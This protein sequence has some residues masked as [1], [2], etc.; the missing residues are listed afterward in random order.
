MPLLHTIN[1]S[2]YY[3]Y[4]DQDFHT[5]SYSPILQSNNE[6]PYPFFLAISDSVNRSSHR[7]T[8]VPIF[9]D[10]I[11][12]QV[13]SEGDRTLQHYSSKS[14]KVPSISPPSLRPEAKPIHPTYPPPVQL[15][16]Q[17]KP[18]IPSRAHSDD[19]SPKLVTDEVVKTFFHRPLPFTLTTSSGSSGSGTSS[20]GS[21]SFRPRVPT[22]VWYRMFS[23]P[24]QADIKDRDENWRRKIG[25]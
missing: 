7:S 10:Q 19:G 22:L 11:R 14:T 9:L 4:S 8:S 15:Q 24:I 25:I 3:G 18:F 21:S 16:T 6:R 5:R 2:A 13:Y 1:D 23:D 17:V 20:S 12:N